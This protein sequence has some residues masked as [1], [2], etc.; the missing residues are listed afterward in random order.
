MRLS[1]SPLTHGATSAGSLGQPI[2]RVLALSAE[3]RR[4]T[5][6]E[7]TNDEQHRQYEDDRSPSNP[8]ASRDDHG[9]T[10]PGNHRSAKCDEEHFP[11]SAS[12]YRH[13]NARQ[14]N[15]V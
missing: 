9:A 1:K 12:S 7:F 6:D 2:T 4:R 14:R 15:Q 13:K 8:P 10:R 11:I 3:R 5:A